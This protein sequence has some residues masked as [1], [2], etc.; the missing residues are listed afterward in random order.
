M[1]TAYEE[2]REWFNSFKSC[3][4]RGEDFVQKHIH[5]LPEHHINEDLI[6]S[7]TN[8]RPYFKIIRSC[9]WDMVD[10]RTGAPLSGSQKTYFYPFHIYMQSDWHN[11]R[12]SCKYPRYDNKI[13]ASIGSKSFCRYEV[14]LIHPKSE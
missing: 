2:M 14:E 6:K 3:K 1:Q 10:M 5:D 7:E 12:Y 11:M 8:G 9:V 13:D 4:R